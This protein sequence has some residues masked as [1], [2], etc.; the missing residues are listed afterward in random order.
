MERAAE[1]AL[2]VALTAEEMAMLTDGEKPPKDLPKIKLAEKSDAE[3]TYNRGNIERVCAVCGKP[4]MG[5]SSRSKYCSEECREAAKAAYNK[6]Q[7]KECK[8]KPEKEM[9]KTKEEL[10]EKEAEEVRRK[11]SAAHL[12]ELTK[13]AREAGMSYGQYMAKKR[14]AK[15]EEA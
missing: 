1:K 13:T 3:A 4:Y 12:D 8:T 14:T 7:S 11:E 9:P 10:S 2:Q 15:G 6:R 5:Y